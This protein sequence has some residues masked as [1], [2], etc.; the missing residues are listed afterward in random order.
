MNRNE[1][2]PSLNQEYRDGLSAGIEKI[3][4]PG[5]RNIWFVVPP[6]PPGKL[7][8]YL[9]AKSVA[10]AGEIIAQLPKLDQAT[11]L[12]RLISY[13]YL[14]KEAV[15]S[16]R[17]EGT[18]STI[19]HVLTPGELIDSQEAKSE[20]ASV[21]GYAHALETELAQVPAEGLKIF[22][23]NLVSRLHKKTMKYDPKFRGTP[24]RI[25]E[26]G[27]PGEVAYIGKIQRP[28]DSI[29]NPTPPRHVLRCLQEVMTWLR[30]EEFAELGDAGMG[31][32]IAVRMAIG[33]AH[34]EAVHPFSDGNGRV[35]RMLLTLQ[36]ACHGKIP[37]YLSGYIEAE[38]S[39]YGHVLQEAQKKLNYG[40]IVEFFSEALIASYREGTRTRE[41]IEN[42]PKL[43][44][45]RAE[46]RKDSTAL[47]ALPWLRDHPIF[48]VKLL[49]DQLSVSA[50]TAHNAVD[51]LQLYGIVRER[52]GFE[53]NRVFA[54]EEVISLLSRRFGSDPDEALE[55][56]RVLMRNPVEK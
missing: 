38:K 54:A 56:A 19:D 31:M 34:F 27:K 30:D 11:D 26:P 35:G 16:S 25:R 20:Q 17:M 32:P 40:P 52:T 12:D 21:R 53:R 22:T 18:M 29:Y 55:G 48:T 33:H 13:L 44:S 4:V 6:A 41:R 43:W 10:R 46:F 8:N 3:D 14:R 5:F 23:V 42:L 15:E 24:G 39:Q 9:P 2:H 50:P 37:I 36:M 28:E 7:P 47:R 49:Q 45:S 1:L 51:Y